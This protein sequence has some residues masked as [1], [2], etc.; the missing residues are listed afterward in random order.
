MR[1]TVGRMMLAIAVFAVALHVGLSYRLSWDY[2]RHSQFYSH[3]RKV[4]LVRARNVESG[5]ARLDGYTAEQKQ[6][7]VEQARRL[8]IYS[9]QMKAKY[10]RAVFIP[11]LPVEPDPAPP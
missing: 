7:A 4:A 5:A 11:W 9:S 8:A 6:K 3:A 10:D 1:F 2:W